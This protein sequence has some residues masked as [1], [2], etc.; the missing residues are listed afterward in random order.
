MYEAGHEHTHELH[1]HHH[2][3]SAASSVILTQLALSIHAFIECM[4]LG[5]QS[6][7]KATLTLL[8]GIGCHK[9]A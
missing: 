1:T 2:I 7:S 8:I 5:S 6:T 4:A 9:W 3:S